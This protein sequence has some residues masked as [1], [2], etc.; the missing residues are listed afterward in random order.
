MGRFRFETDNKGWQTMRD[1]SIAWKKSTLL[2]LFSSSATSILLVSVGTLLVTRIYTPS[3]FGQYSF[4][5]TL[6]ILIA[7]LLTATYE[8]FIVPSQTEEESILIFRKGLYRNFKNSIFLLVITTLIYLLFPDEILSID[9]YIDPIILAT[10]LASIYGVYNLLTQIALRRL[11]YATVST[12]ALIQN[13]TIYSSQLLLGN[14]PL[15]SSGLIVGEFIG[16]IITI[17]FIS[18]RIRLNPSIHFQRPKGANSISR[19]QILTNTTATIFEIITA[20]S[21]FFYIYLTENQ[22][23]SGNFA[24]AQ[25]LLTVPIILFGTTTAQYIFASGSYSVRQGIH[26]SRSEL[27]QILIKLALTSFAIGAGV[28][29]FGSLAV[30]FVLDSNWETVG[31]LITI[32]SPYLI[33][34]LIWAQLSFTFYTKDMWRSYFFFATFRFSFTI[35]VL[36]I[37]Y[38]N[39]VAISHVIHL[40]LGT[41][42]IVSII[43]ICFLRKKH[44]T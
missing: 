3:Q 42:S 41:N 12:R 21:L 33:I 44:G 40:A 34:S 37:C 7:P 36:L 1:N 39:E 25:K 15:K 22:E 38:V 16:R 35:V 26:M 24:L 30:D 19:S 43:A 14:S 11:D 4:I 18:K 20:S 8:F 31:S 23:S 9:A 10:M 29:L 28:F 6:A 17:V 13:G 5:L 27:D 32:M 2:R